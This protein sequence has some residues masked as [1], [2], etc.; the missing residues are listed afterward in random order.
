M[1]MFM[2]GQLDEINPSFSGPI[3]QKAGWAPWWLDYVGFIYRF[4]PD[5][6]FTLWQFDSLLWKTPMKI[7]DTYLKWWF[8]IAA[9]NCRRY[10]S[11]SFSLSPVIL[12]APSLGWPCWT[13]GMAAIPTRFKWLPNLSG[14]SARWTQRRAG[15]ARMYQSLPEGVGMERQMS[16]VGCSMANKPW[17]DEWL[18]AGK[19][20]ERMGKD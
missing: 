19:L 12:D 8:S 5:Y 15:G 10:M 7:D 2:L 1:C 6:N 17:P 20:G 9:L 16:R 13:V 14:P 3:P 18:G 11:V 4:I